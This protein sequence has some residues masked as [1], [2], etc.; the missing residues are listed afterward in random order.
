MSTW[1]ELGKGMGREW[2]RKARAREE[3][4]SKRGEAAPFIVSGIPGCCQVTVGQSLDRM[5]TMGKG[6]VSGVEEWNWRSPE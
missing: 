4:E 2:G 6:V 5:L 3:Q 1:R